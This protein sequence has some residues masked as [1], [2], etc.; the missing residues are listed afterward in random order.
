MMR[1]KFNREFNIEAARLVTSRDV[2]VAQDADE[3]DVAE[4]VLRRW[5]RELIATP[6]A[7]LQYSRIK[8][9]VYRTLHSALPSTSLGGGTDRSLLPS[10]SP[11][12]H[13]D[14]RRQILRLSDR[15]VW[16]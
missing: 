11:C 13:L 9:S 6:A 15:L 5:M 3:L 14:S 2:A 8:A 4:S 12:T 16:E 1:R 7:A 10:Y